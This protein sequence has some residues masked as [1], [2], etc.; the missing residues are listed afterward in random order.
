MKKAI[1]NIILAVLAVAGLVFSSVSN[2]L[3][4]FIGFM[5]MCPSLIALVKVNTKWLEEY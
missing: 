3:Q 2:G 1:I 5:V 4:F